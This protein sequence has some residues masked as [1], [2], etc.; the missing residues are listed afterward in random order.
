MNWSATML[1]EAPG[2]C[3]DERTRRRVVPR[4]PPLATC[5]QVQLRPTTW[6]A[7]TY[8]LQQLKSLLELEDSRSATQLQEILEE[9]TWDPEKNC[10]FGSQRAVSRI[11]GMAQSTIGEG[12]GMSDRSGKRP[13]LLKWLAG[14]GI[15]VAGI[16]KEWAAGKVSDKYIAKLIVYAGSMAD[17]RPEEGRKWL[18][19]IAGVGFRGAIHQMKGREDLLTRADARGQNLKYQRQT[20]SRIQQQGRSYQHVRSKIVKGVTTMVPRHLENR[21]R[22]AGVS[23]RGNWRSHADATT[24]GAVSMS[25]EGYAITGDATIGEDVRQMLMRRG[26]D[27][28]VVWSQERIS[29]DDAREVGKLA[30]REGQK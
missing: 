1:T 15:S 5:G 4:Y 8:M 7:S 20:C 10:Y 14:E 28:S 22:Q 12:L 23:I 21:A 13:K 25:E 30:K 26:W 16:Q 2:L 27:G 17:S 19:L 11:T 29:C 24:L 3:R 6:L 18:A 9:L